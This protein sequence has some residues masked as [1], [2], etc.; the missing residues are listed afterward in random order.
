AAVATYTKDVDQKLAAAGGGAMASAAFSVVDLAAG[1]KLSAGIG[2]EIML[3]VGSAVCSTATPPGLID[4]TE[5]G[6]LDHGQ[7]LV[8]NHLYMATIEGR[9]VVAKG[10]VKLLVRGSY[11]IG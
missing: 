1:Q 3:R 7:A 2:C 9:G 5:S 4:M 8:K 6:T 10:A 11:T